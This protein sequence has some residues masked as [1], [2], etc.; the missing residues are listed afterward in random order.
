ML[1]LEYAGEES[2]GNSVDDS[3]TGPDFILSNEEESEI[4]VSGSGEDDEMIIERDNNEDIQIINT[5]S[6][7]EALPEVF[8]KRLKKKE[9]GPPNRWRSNYLVQQRISTSKCE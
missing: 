4:M 8:F 2:E 1:D 5:V 3:D 9:V 7:D 6:E